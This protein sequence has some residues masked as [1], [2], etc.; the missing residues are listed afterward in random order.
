MFYL[1]KNGLA[2]LWGKIKTALDKKLDKSGGTIS[3]PLMSPLKVER[4]GTGGNFGSIEFLK[5][6]TSYG[7]IGIAT[8]DG[9]VYHVLSDTAQQFAMLDS[10]NYK[11]IISTSDSSSAAALSSSDTN[12]PTVRDIY[13]GLPNI[14]GSHAYTSGTSIYAPTST[15][16]TGYELISNGSGAPIW[17]APSYAVCSTSASTAAKTASIANFKLVTGAT[18]KIKFTYAHTSSSAATL[19]VNSTGAKTIYTHSG[20]SNVSVTSS[21]SWRAGEIVEF[22]YDG[23]YWVAVSSDN[24]FVEVSSVGMQN[25]LNGKLDGSWSD[26]NGGYANI[27]ELSLDVSDTYNT[28]FGNLGS[29]NEFVG[30]YEVAEQV[31]ANRDT[32]APKSHAS[33]ATTYG[34]GTSSNYGHVKLSDSTSTTSGASAGVAATPT[35][36][37]AAYDKANIKKC[38]TTGYG[39]YDIIPSNS[40]GSGIFLG[41]EL[42]FEYEEDYYNYPTNIL[43]AGLGCVNYGIDTTNVIYAG[44]YLLFGNSNSIHC[45][46]YNLDRDAYIDVGKGTSS[47]RS[48]AFRVDTQGRGYFA[49]SVSGTGADYAE[50]W[51]WSDG[52]PN[53]ED[54]VGYFVSFNGAKIRFA[55][56]NDDL[57]KVGIVS[58]R[59]AVVGDD[60]DDEWQ[61]KFLTD[62][63]GRYLTKTIEEDGQT[64]E[65]FVLN[66]EYDPTQEYIPREKRKEFSKIGTHGKLVVRDDGTC[67]VDG[68]C[69]PTDGGIATASDNGFYVMERINDTLI[70]VYLR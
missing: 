62:E 58:A 14:N 31:S 40:S 26:A 60:Y 67:Q 49:V 65:V 70:R 18:V 59:P 34:I 48:N 38:S 37:K 30:L 13:Y 16:N 25:A 10:N 55:N 22:V 51:E 44:Q 23:S 5:N 54:R 15:G 64:R 68:Y 11:S 39:G 7:H 35:A 32:K 52:N 66:P 3:S 9:D 42:G 24:G 57:R 63:Y 12:Y 33:T 1:D 20:T 61:G 21:H 19:N 28:V 43:G 6:S 27:G 36:V 46:K 69:R 41:G 29:D 45:G 53:N 17:K 47:E 2:Y 4:T 8:V 56:K 50:Q